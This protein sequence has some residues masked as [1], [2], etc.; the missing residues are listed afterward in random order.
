M[1][2]QPAVTLYKNTHLFAQKRLVITKNTY[3]ILKLRNHIAPNYN[4]EAIKNKSMGNGFFIK[5]ERGIGFI[6]VCKIECR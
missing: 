5:L 1:C 6:D 2:L 4:P 3:L